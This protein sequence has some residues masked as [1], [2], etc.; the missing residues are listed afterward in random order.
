M[1]NLQRAKKFPTIFRRLTG[2]TPQ[3]FEELTTVLKEA[4]LGQETDY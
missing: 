1:F 4:H 3:A 2:I